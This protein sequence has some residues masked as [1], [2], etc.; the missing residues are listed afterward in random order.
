MK[1]SILGVLLLVLTITLIGCGKNKEKTIKVIATEEPHAE[2]LREAKPL[3]KEQGYN[4]EITVTNNYELG[5]PAVENGSADANYFQH[6]PYFNQQNK[7]GNLVNVGAIHLEPIGLY[8]GTVNNIDNLKDGDEIIISDN[9]PDYGRIVAFLANIGLVTTI[10]G[11]DQ[12]KEID[13]PEKGIETKKVNFKFKIIAAKLLVTAKNNNEGALFFIN[14]NYA[15]T[16]NLDVKTAL[17]TELSTNN[18]YANIVVVKKGNEDDPKIKALLE[19][20][21]S[22]HIKN[23]INTKYNGTVI[24]VKK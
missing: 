22:E 7:N 6:I 17:V 4:L 5:N 19:V 18:P 12:L 11:F 2:I 13:S 8:A 10:D 16:G 9:A 15:I 24:L 20:L 23:F 14:G 3:L 21:Q 1:K